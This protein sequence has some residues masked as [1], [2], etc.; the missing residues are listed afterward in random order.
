MKKDFALTGSHADF[1]RAD[2]ALLDDEFGAVD[3]RSDGSDEGGYQPT[4]I[5]KVPKPVK[6]KK[7]TSKSPAK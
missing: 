7:S 1:E 4:L 5:A 6:S 3:S 2:D